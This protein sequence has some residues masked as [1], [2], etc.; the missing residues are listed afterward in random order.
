MVYRLA[1]HFLKVGRPQLLLL[2]DDEATGSLDGQMEEGV[3][4][5]LR[6]EPLQYVVG[7]TDFYGCTFRVAPGVLIPRPETEE[8]VDL[9]VKEWRG[10]APRIIDFG[11]GS[12]CIPVSLAHE[13]QG[14]AVRSVDISE[15]ALS[16]ARQNA[17]SNGVEV[18][19]VCADM[20]SYRSDDLFDV[21]VSNPPYVMS[22]EK[23]LMRENVLCY[24]PH[25]AL[26]VADDDP[27]EFYRP[28]ADFASRSLAPDGA[29]Y[30][31]INQQLGPQTAD[32]FL[33]KGMKAEVLK[34]MFGVDRFVVAR[35]K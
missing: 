14:A 31:E 21:V 22:S 15:E 19:F 34:D 4:R 10:R 17:Q 25:L 24:E 2:L 35:W 26:F 33:A 28:I 6:H 30:M 8:M 5:L 13:L 23:A 7:E 3:S 18:D 1:E 32:L 12:G 20:R 9:I 27:L 16:I 11:T 29:A